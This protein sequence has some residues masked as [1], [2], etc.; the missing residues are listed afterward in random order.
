MAH[1]EKRVTSHGAR[2]EVRYRAPDGGERS[3]TFRTRRD[4]DRF[5]FTVEA[6][7]LRGAWVDPRSAARSFGDVARE[8]LGS[9]PAK[10]PG[11]WARDE[12]ILRVHLLPAL[13]SQP[14]GRVT[15][16]TVRHIV[17]EWCTHLRPRTVRRHYGVLRAVFAFAVESGA[18]VAS[19]CRGIRLP[20][21]E[22]LDRRIVTAEDLERLADELGEEYRTLAYLG[23]VLGLRW[24]E[25]AGLRVGRVD[26]LRGTL[27][28]A[29]Q[30][31]RGLHGATLFGPPK[32]AAG[33]RTLA[34]P[35]AI[36]EMLA[37]QLARRGLTGEDADALVFAMP[38][39]EVLEYENFRHRVWLPA[40]RRADLDGL[41]FH[42]LRRANATGLVAEGVD[43]K[44]AQ[45]RLGHSDPRLTLAVY[46]QATT[47]ADRAAADVLEARFVRAPRDIRG[48]ES[49]RRAA[50]GPRDPADLPV[51]WSGRRD[52]NPRPQRPERCALTKLRYVPKDQES[53]GVLAAAGG[54]ASSRFASR[55]S[56]PASNGF[57]SSPSASARRARKR[58][59]SRSSSS[60]M[61][62]CG[63]RPADSSRRRSMAT[64]MPPMLPIWR[65]S[66]A[67]S[68]CSA[69]TAARTSCPRRTS[70]TRWPGPTNA[71]RT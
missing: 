34:I 36:V 30:A 26:F 62:V 6:D 13:G 31:T 61:A 49:S 2:Y 47:E 52:S 57:T 1:V 45:T 41:T 50:A 56:E 59:A 11:T 12:S 40:C 70:A 65:S 14:I 19:P 21:V 33:R 27:T 66:T 16:A 68:G 8:W 46:A 37:D 55:R 25:C 67:R 54:D 44:T 24:G 29:E 22:H 28:V 32:S 38:G 4:A 64:A 53:S 15:P 69:A 51:R 3:R 58:S 5:A 48:T 43:L 17:A 35:G 60:R 20:E 18:L 63:R 42:D 10:R 23:A 39:G 71:D 9:N 7:K